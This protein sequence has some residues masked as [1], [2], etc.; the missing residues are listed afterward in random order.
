MR[1]SIAS[2]HV[3]AS[4]GAS[5][6]DEGAIRETLAHPQ[7]AQR[8]SEFPGRHDTNLFAD[9]EN[10][11]KLRLELDLDI[12][13]AA[14]WCRARAKR[15]R[16][17]DVYPDDRT[18]FVATT[19]LPASPVVVGNASRRRR[20]LHRHEPHELEATWD[21]FSDQFSLL[22][23]RAAE[24]G[25]RL[26]EG[27]SNFAWDEHN[28]LRYLDDDL[29]PWD[30]GLGLASSL[31]VLL[32][33]HEWIAEDHAT[34]LGRALRQSFDRLP[35]LLSFTD[36]ISDIRREPH[37]H[38]REVAALTEA[39]GTPAESRNL[40]R[41]RVTAKAHTAVLG[42]IHAN[43]SALVA[44][45][46]EP[47]VR[48][49]AQIL[50]LGDIVGYGPQPAECIEFLAELPQVIALRGNHDHAAVDEAE[51]NL[52]VK[53]ARWAIDWTRANL[54]EASLSWLESLPDELSGDGWMAVHGSLV[55]PSRHRA[56]IY[57]LTAD[58]NLDA[59]EERRA[60]LLLH[61]HTHIPGAWAR[62]NSNTSAYWVAP[63]ERLRLRDHG[64]ALLSPGSV[65]QSRD[66]NINAS[67]AIW[68]HE[69]H[70]VDFHRVPYDVGHTL[71]TMQREGFPSTL[72][73]RLLNGV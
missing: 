45:L 68:D 12:D 50:V 72:Q 64:A 13:E 56:Y 47:A 10:V 62:S 32:R 33:Q 3:V 61:G 11:V 20:P 16:S 73:R 9:A 8:G 55:E 26:D 52:F 30:H 7:S 24:L 37:P 35:L 6:P 25:W 40:R 53:D 69:Q 1:E 29:Y 43:L 5:P 49:A 19:S 51:A 67:F 39:L 22:Y 66:K 31:G 23:S 44:V 2:L 63:G 60:S 14:I 71:T 48:S 57:V 65:G 18:W 34:R 70:T 54:D 41:R 4:L 28:R 59:L 15:E 17:L 21:Q 42:D 27:V 58:D 36:L 46:N 38:P